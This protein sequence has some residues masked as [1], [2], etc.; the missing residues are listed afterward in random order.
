M[1]KK[2]KG[3]LDYKYEGLKRDPWL[4]K[5]FAG[6]DKVHDYHRIIYHRIFYRSIWTVTILHLL[7]SLSAFSYCDDSGGKIHWTVSNRDGVTLQE[8]S[9]P[10][11]AFGYNATDRTEVAAFQ[12]SGTYKKDVRIDSENICEIEIT[13]D[14]ACER[15]HDNVVTISTSSDMGIA[16]NE[17]FL[18]AYIPAVVADARKLQGTC[19]LNEWRTVQSTFMPTK[20]N[21]RISSWWKAET[22][23][24]YHFVSKI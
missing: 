18:N 14:Y 23:C 2:R 17:T 1:E 24:R 10:L 15:T 3:H 7:V 16:I 22:K 6:T 13:Y 21:P 9:Y 20:I 4:V 19:T 8:T 11:W 5:M 12:W